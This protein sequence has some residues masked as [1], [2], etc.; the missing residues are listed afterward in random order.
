MLTATGVNVVLFL[1]FVRFLK[2][3]ERP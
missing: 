3:M 1:A 2:F